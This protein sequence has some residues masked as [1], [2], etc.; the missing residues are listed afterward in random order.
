MQTDTDMVID[1]PTPDAAEHVRTVSDIHTV[2]SHVVWPDAA[3]AVRDT[4][5]IV[6]P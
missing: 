1:V 2:L 3:F 4:C 5:A 6:L